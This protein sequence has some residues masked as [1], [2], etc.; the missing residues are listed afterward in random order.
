MK[1][2]RITQICS[3][4]TPHVGRAA[5][6]NGACAPRPLILN[7]G[8]IF[9]E[10][11]GGKIVEVLKVKVSFFRAHP[12]SL[13]QLSIAIATTTRAPLAYLNEPQPEII[14]PSRRP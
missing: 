4:R 13:S 10:K 6:Y 14:N 12:L 9:R 7:V 8:C 1:S 5:L 2:G 3:Q 11:G